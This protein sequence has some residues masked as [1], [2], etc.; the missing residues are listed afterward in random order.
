MSYKVLYTVA[1]EVGLKTKGLSGKL[2]LQDG[3]VAITGPEEL[4]LPYSEFE[5]LE[6]TRQ[7]KVGTLIHLRCAGT[8]VFLTVPRF[9]LLGA[10]AVINYFKTHELFNELWQRI[11]IQ[12]S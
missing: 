8:S 6:I 9:H 5:E 3:H 12:P 2:E 7:H 11:K 10:F 1:E 4:S